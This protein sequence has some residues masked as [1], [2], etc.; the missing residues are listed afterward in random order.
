MDLDESNLIRVV[1]LGSGGVGKSALTHRYVS[2]TFVEEYDPTIE[3]SY[4]KNLKLNDKS[5][6]I[7]IVDTAGQEGFSVLQD[8]WIQ[9]GHAFLLVYSIT[10]RL[11]LEALEDIYDS[12]SDVKDPKDISIVLVGNKCDLESKRLIDKEKGKRQAETWGCSF[13]E[14]SAKEKIGNEK[15]FEDVIKSIVKKRGGNDPSSAR[16]GMFRCCLL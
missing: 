11:S 8:Q 12:I 9:R 4:R 10:E 5:W 3:D 7:E 15:V 6:K 14:V 1:V 13:H 2:G 16:S